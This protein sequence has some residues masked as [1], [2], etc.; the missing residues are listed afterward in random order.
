MRHRH[1]VVVWIAAFPLGLN[2]PTIL[3][4]GRRAPCAASHP[5]GHV[6]HV[7]DNARISQVTGLREVVTVKRDVREI[8]RH[9]WRAASVTEGKVECRRG[10]WN[11]SGADGNDASIFG[12]ERPKWAAGISNSNR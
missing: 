8:Q 5:S 1:V 10:A 12:G 11:K 7:R 2:C 4:V 9:G 6:E 3:I